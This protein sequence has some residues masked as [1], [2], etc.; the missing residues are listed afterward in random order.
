[1]KGGRTLTENE[2]SMRYECRGEDCLR[3]ER[4]QEKKVGEKAGGVV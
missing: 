1:M 4:N 3:R 2:E